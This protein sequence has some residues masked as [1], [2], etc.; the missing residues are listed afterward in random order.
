[1]M[2]CPNNVQSTKMFQTASAA[3]FA[4][5]WA[6]AYE[7]ENY[8]SGGKF[9]KDSELRKI[10]TSIKS[11]D[12]Y[13]WLYLYSNNATKQAIKDACEAYKRFFL[14]QARHPRFKSKRRSKPSFYVDTSQIK[15]TDTHVKIEGI[16]KSRKKNHQ[17]ANW[18]RL[19]ERGRVPTNAKYYNPRIKFDGLHW[20]IT[21]GVDF[22]ESN[23]T[24][25]G[26]G[27]GIDLGIKDLAICSDGL[28]YK[29]I[30]KSKKVKGLQ[31][32]KRRL[33]RK[34]SRKYLI[35]KR[36][37][38]YCKTCNITKSEHDVLRVSRKLTN[39][40]HNHLHQVIS[41][42][43]NRKPKFIVLE[44]LNVHGMMKNRHLSK[45]VQNQCFYEFRR[46]MEYKCQWSNVQLIIADRFFPSSKTCSCC[47]ETKRNLTLRDRIFVCDSCGFTI[48]R[49]LQAAINL[50]RYGE[51]IIGA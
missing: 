41:E 37:E 2:L 10:F 8:K 44:D 7:D 50:Q 25:K 48:D 11:A 39:I 4:Y 1:M 19:A 24:P 33:Q 35:N 38:R 34:V 17:K 3:R 9:I 28:T 45:A 22:E 29:N 32:K 49:D 30:N 40:R 21:V 12:E 31:R 36:G 14:K 5:N 43:M 47:G 13:S 51:S 16:A 42:I 6:I 20:W 26:Y 18:I 46:I 27:I 23:E 15:F